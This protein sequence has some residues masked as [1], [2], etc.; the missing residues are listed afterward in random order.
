M[1]HERDTSVRQE[2]SFDFDNDTRKYI[3]SHPYIYYIVNERLQEEQQ[4]HSKN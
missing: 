3:F 4:F 2:K 1:Q